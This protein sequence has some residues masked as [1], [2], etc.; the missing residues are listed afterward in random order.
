M[1]KLSRKGNK[2][3]EIF[4]VYEEKENTYRHSS[5][6][7]QCPCCSSQPGKHFAESKKEKKRNVNNSG[8]QTMSIGIL[9]YCCTS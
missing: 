2:K 7:L 5:G 4:Q 9:Y 3:S 8:K 6:L 1:G